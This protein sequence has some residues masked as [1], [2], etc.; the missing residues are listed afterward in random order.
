MGERAREVMWQRQSE[1][2]QRLHDALEVL[3][4]VDAAPTAAPSDS[5]W[6]EW[7][8]GTP[9]SQFVSLRSPLPTRLVAVPASAQHTESPA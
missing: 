3:P 9:R 2:P 5:A 4:P 7:A 8:S 1:Y 6:S